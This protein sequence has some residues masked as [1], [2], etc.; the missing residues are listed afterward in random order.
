MLKYIFIFLFLLTASNVSMAEDCNKLKKLSKDF[1]K[2][3]AG[4]LKTKSSDIKKNAD[5]KLNKNKHKI[6]NYD[7]KEMLLKFKNSK[8][9]KEFIN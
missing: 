1:I 4:I 5:L 3:K 2:C 6:K 8:S 9:H 7:I